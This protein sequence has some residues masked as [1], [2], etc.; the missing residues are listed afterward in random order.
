MRFW[1]TP[2]G[3]LRYASSGGR[4]NALPN[5]TSSLRMRALPWGP[6]KPRCHCGIKLGSCYHADRSGAV[7]ELVDIYDD[8]NEP[9]GSMLRSEAQR[10]G[11]WIRSFHCWILDLDSR[12]VVFQKRAPSKK[13]Y[14]SYWDISAA[15]HYIAGEAL[16]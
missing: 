8:N 5:S 6:N 1:L 12:A 2:R 4:R 13:V 15:G 11:H 7:A 3:Q 10:K 16:S 9:Q 14:P